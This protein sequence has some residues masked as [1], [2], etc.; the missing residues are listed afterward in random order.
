MQQ[1]SNRRIRL[2]HALLALIPVLLVFA[3]GGCKKQ[4]Q[5][6]TQAQAQPHAQQQAQQ[7][8]QAQHYQL[9]GTVVSVN[10]SNSSLVVDMQAIPGY[11][12]A[13]TM[14]YPVHGS[15]A[16]ANLHAGDVITADLVNAS[17]GAYLDNVQ[18][19]KKES[20][21]KKKPAGR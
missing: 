5:S 4:T 15:T 6:Q 12:G 13:M 19:A 10:A 11:M 17:D 3:L 16:L 1:K 9:K 2:A 8:T 18:V 21:E 7:Q 20:A 14:S